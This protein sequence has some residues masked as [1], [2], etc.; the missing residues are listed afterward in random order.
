MRY[1]TDYGRE[2]MRTIMMTYDGDQNRY[3][4]LAGHGYRI[5][6]QAVK[7]DLP[8]DIKCPALLIC[9]DKDHAGSTKRYNR[10]WHKKSGISIEWIEGAGLT[11]FCCYPFLNNVITN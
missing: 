8:Y 5:L 7:A 4:A 6:A 9:G 3:A 10:A 11:I 1:W 2:L